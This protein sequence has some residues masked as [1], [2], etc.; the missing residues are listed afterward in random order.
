MNTFM[1]EHPVTSR[2]LRQLSADAGVAIDP[3]VALEDLPAAINR[4]RSRLNIVEPISKAL[5]CGD[6]GV[7]AMA[8]IADIVAA[9]D[10]VAPA[11]AALA[12]DAPAE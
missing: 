4:L 12:A 5:A 9:I 6:V 3:G 1:W 2:H 10:R 7:G 8:S 11:P